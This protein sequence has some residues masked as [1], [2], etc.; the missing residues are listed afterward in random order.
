MAVASIL[1]ILILSV[2]SLLAL[3]ADASSLDC[4][5]CL[6]LLLPRVSMSKDQDD[7]PLSWR[8]G[9]DGLIEQSFCFGGQYWNTATC[10]SLNGWSCLCASSDLNN[11]NDSIATAC[12]E[13]LDREGKSNLNP[14]AS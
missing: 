5:V 10:T 3:I 6:S 11:V 12:N 9:A 14:T 2:I 1:S 13:I 8:I 4:A 7:I